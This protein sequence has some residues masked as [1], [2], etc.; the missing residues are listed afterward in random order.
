MMHE[1]FSLSRRKPTI[2]LLLAAFLASGMALS[3]VEAFWQPRFAT[4][5]GGSEG[6]S[7]VFGVLL[8]GSF[9]LGMLGNL[10]SMPLSRL[11]RQRYGLVAAL[12]QGL[13]GVALIVLALQ[14]ETIAAALFFWLLYLSRGTL[15]SP[16]A[17]LFSQEVPRARR[18][19]MLSV[20]SLATYVGAFLASTGLGYV[21]ERASIGTAWTIAGVI[22][23][24]SMF[25]YVQVD[26]RRARQKRTDQ[27]PTEVPDESGC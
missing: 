11:F 25:L 3:V 19:S 24:L 10:L 23:V 6:N 1:A 17:T 8:A 21:A 7:V 4:L 26:V 2:L 5:L 15:H 16:H 13:Q 9:G 14:T 20:Q 27:N 18:S 12:F 22:I